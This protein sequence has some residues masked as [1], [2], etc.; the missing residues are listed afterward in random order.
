MYNSS[1]KRGAGKAST[2][3]SAQLGTST[4]ARPDPKRVLGTANAVAAG[5][6]LTRVGI[7]SDRELDWI[8][9]LAFGAASADAQE[10]ARA[11]EA[12][13]RKALSQAR[14]A[15]W[16]DTTEARQQAFLRAREEDKEAAER[17][18][19]ALDELYAQ[20][21]EE[22]RLAKIAAMEL[23]R[24]REDPRGRNAKSALM[25]HEAIKA[26]EEQLAFQA[27]VKSAQAIANEQE[28]NAMLMEQWGHTAEELQK[29]LAARE[30]NMAEKNYNLEMV[31][32]QIQERKQQRAEEK[33]EGERARAEAEEEARENAAEEAERKQRGE[34]NNLYNKASA[35][36]KLS[37][38]GKL[39][40][41]LQENAQDE[42]NRLR[43]EAHMA[44]MKQAALERQ[45]R[46]QEAFEQRKAVG[47]R[48][49]EQDK[50]TDSPKRRTQDRF[51]GK[52]ES[53]LNRMAAGDV[54]RTQ[55][56]KE[57]RRQQ[58][59][60]EKAATA[61]AVAAAAGGTPA[62]RYNKAEA[63]ASGFTSPA[64]E[65]AYLA[66]M[67][68]L[69]ETI[70]TEQAAEAAARKA[71]AR[72]VEEI[73]K[74]QAEEKRERT[75]REVEAERANARQQRAYQAEEDARY[76]AFIASQIPDDMNPTLKAKAM[77]LE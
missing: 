22:E 23:Q 28:R 40:E 25:L 41:R 74:M 37:K 47:L 66:E 16:T 68:T 65:Q 35:K 62:K 38:S 57:A 52:G 42:A 18:K 32:Y 27:S 63:T 54:A 72:R 17:R 12:A 50:A 4:R 3:S 39:Q 64:E 51:E 24:L 60:E 31:L 76:R 58:V 8:R 33:Q 20:Q 77:K 67:R 29:R 46:K 1:G 75:R 13:R 11:A 55:H 14:T 34:E 73:Q 15:N 36:P 45:Q 53:F 69:P 48:Q 21:K 2:G 19:V 10:Q 30:L 59:E 9:T 5:L 44:E 6:D 43:Q 7:M 49:Y 71:E 61:A 70:R 26:R 56:A